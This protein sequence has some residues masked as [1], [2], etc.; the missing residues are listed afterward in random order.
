MRKFEVMAEKK[1]TTK[2]LPSKPFTGEE[3][4]TFSSTNQPAPE[5]KSKGWERWRA[6]RHL[7]QSIIK[8]MAEG[9]NLTE[10]IKSLVANAKAGNAKAI[11]TINKGIED[12]AIIKVANVNPD[13]SP[14]Q[15]GP[16]K[17]QIV[18]PTDE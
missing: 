12:D 8:E 9:E 16:F 3:G 13:G 14:V 6:E 4:N 2:K 11:E 5:L 10:Y 17:V 15:Q 1:K 7:T 18:E